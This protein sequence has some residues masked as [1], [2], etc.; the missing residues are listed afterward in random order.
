M[1]GHE[2]LEEVK[3]LLSCYTS[4]L[5]LVVKSLWSTA[6]NNILSYFAFLKCRKYNSCED[7]DHTLSKVQ[8]PYYSGE[9]CS[10]NE[11]IGND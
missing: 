5:V 1:A 2:N 4:D 7:G 9:S 11:T 8:F 10:L 3:L 6:V